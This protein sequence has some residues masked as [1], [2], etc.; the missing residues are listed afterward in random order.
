MFA[1]RAGASHVYAVDNASILFKAQQNAIE[2][3]LDSKI[4][5]L[6]G[7][8]EH[9][10]LPVDKV[11]VIIS[12]WMGYFLL[13]EG[14]LDSVFYAR[15]KWL[16]PDGIMAPSRTDI[17]LVPIQDEEWVNGMQSSINHFYSL[18]LYNYINTLHN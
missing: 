17:L 14:M 4:T 16:K 3:G 6:K 18:L 15:D 1:A 8:I 7:K 13:F 2:N 11:D 5:F 9:I 10:L 12:E